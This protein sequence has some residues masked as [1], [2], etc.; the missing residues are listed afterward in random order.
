M[1]IC[2]LYVFVTIPKHIAR[3][4]AVKLRMPARQL[5]FEDKIRHLKQ[6]RFV[7]AF[8]AFVQVVLTGLFGFLYFGK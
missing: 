1:G 6:W 7:A 8:F 5:F 2:A 3:C 4:Q